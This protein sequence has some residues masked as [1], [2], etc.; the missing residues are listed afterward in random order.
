MFFDALEGFP[1]GGGRSWPPGD[2]A[3]RDAVRRRMGRLLPRLALAPEELK[4]LPDPYVRAVEAKTF[5]DA[6]DPKEPA[7]PFLPPDLDR[8]DGPWVLLG[9]PD[10]KPLA[11]HHATHF[12][13]HATFLIYIPLP[14]GRAATLDC[15]ERL[16]KL[17]A[18]KEIPQPPEGSRLLLR[19]RAMLLAARGEPV[20]SPITQEVQ[21]R[22]A[23]P[24]GERAEGDG[25]FDF[26]LRRA[27]I[28][29][30]KPGLHATGVGDREPV[31]FFHRGPA[32]D[33]VRST[34]RECHGGSAAPSSV[35]RN[36]GRDRQG[37]FLTDGRAT[38]VSTPEREAE[39]TAT[40]K[41]S[42]RTWTTLRGIWPRD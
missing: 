6:F 1:L 40:A 20:L 23:R 24:A 41:R 32:R 33:P 28:V 29:D 31:F 15:L 18:A 42:D 39:A 10:G 38:L 14:A 5:P 35:L 25:V 11:L 34:C 37:H 17:R 16:S 4:A 36:A 27:E 30:G 2:A 12:M 22:V 3:D 8:P 13:G 7:R 26:R 9:D 21:I 19:R